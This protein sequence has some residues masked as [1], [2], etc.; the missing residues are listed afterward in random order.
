MREGRWNIIAELLNEEVIVKNVRGTESYRFDSISSHVRLLE[1][2]KQRLQ[3]DRR[4]LH[5]DMLKERHEQGELSKLA[6]LTD[7]MAADLLLFLRGQLEGKEARSWGAPWAPWSSV[8]LE[9]GDTPRFL[10]EAR[11]SSAARQLGQALGVETVEELRTRFA[12]RMQSMNE[13]LRGRSMF[14]DGPFQ[15]FDPAEIGTR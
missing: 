14:W 3:L 1:F 13:L 4:S 6:P 9:R 12:A 2:R 7:F 8:Y 11:R 5:A 10:I 15:N